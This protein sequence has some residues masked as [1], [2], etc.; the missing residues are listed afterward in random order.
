MVRLVALLATKSKICAL[1]LFLNVL[2]A[3]WHLA[4]VHLRRE[5]V[6]VAA[7]VSSRQ[8]I[9]IEGLATRPAL[10]VWLV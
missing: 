6:S 3:E 4:S 7:V 1:R 2:E 8:S 10:Q 9:S 5:D